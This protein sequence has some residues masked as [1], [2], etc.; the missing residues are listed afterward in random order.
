M[1]RRNVK[2]GRL[3]AGRRIPPESPGLSGNPAQ[4]DQ[5]EPSV[6]AWVDDDLLRKTQAVWSAVYGR[7]VPAAEAVEILVNVKAL[8]EV[9]LDVDR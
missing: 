9:L 4:Q 1:S 5:G 3:R 8:A 6:P 7:D 2:H